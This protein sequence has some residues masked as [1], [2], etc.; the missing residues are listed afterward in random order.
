M[1]TLRPSQAA[2]YDV[3][4]AERKARFIQAVDD[5]ILSDE[6]PTGK[7]IRYYYDKSDGEVLNAAEPRWRRER[8]LQ[9]GFVETGEGV[10]RRFRPPPIGTFV[11]SRV[12]LKDAHDDGKEYTHGVPG[13][14]GVIIQYCHRVTPTVCWG[15]HVDDDFTVKKLVDAGFTEAHA[16]VTIGR[17][18]GHG[19]YDVSLVDQAEVLRA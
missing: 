6:P 1:S 7:N 10:A 18:T 15:P 14:V 17:C 11:K 9:L 3:R 16:L 12:D 5:C 8:L 19:F 13:T 4:Y 2:E